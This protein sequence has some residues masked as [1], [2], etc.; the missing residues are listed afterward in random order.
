MAGLGYVLSDHELHLLTSAGVVEKEAFVNSM[1]NDDEKRL[2]PDFSDRMCSA[3]AKKIFIEDRNRMQK[4]KDFG[5][6][7]SAA[8]H[9][10]KLGMEWEKK[11][12]Y[13]LGEHIHHSPSPDEIANEMRNSHLW[14]F[15]RAFF[16]LRHSDKVQFYGRND[17]KEF[18]LA[19]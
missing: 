15:Y 10:F 19:A 2:V 3:L 13:F 18:K 6:R 14:D 12:E 8:I 4:F 7:P 5:P 17:S 1:L 11:C 16:V 9:Y